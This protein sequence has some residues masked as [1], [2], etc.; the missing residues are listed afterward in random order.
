MSSVRTAAPSNSLGFPVSLTGRVV[1]DPEVRAAGRSE[2]CVI[3]L[4][5][6]RRGADF[7]AGTFSVDALTFGPRAREVAGWLGEGCRVRVSGTLD[8]GE[9]PTAAG[10]R[11]L[12]LQL[13]VEEIVLEEISLVDRF[14][15]KP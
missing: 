14:G 13:L 7:G 1:A 8:V 10:P 4:A 11:R 6:P 3:R 2:V 9:D 5:V 15:A 12:G